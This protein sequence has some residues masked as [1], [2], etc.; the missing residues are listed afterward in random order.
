VSSI[1]VN[2]PRHGLPTASRADLAHIPGNDGWP[3]VGDTFKFLADPLGSVQEMAR[4]YGPVHR[5]RV[6]GIRTVG[7]QGPD[8]IGLVLFDQAK[9]FSSAE[10]WEP[11]LGLLFPRG[12]ML[13]DFDEHRLHR[14]ALSV[15]F[16][17]GPLKAYLAALN[18]GIAER[19]A[20]WRQGP[21]DFLFYPAI[22][23]LTLDLA[24][25]S[26]L[27]EAIG[28]DV[29]AIKRAFIDTVAAATGVIRRP[30]PGTAMRRGVNGRAVIV[31]YFS[32]QAPLRR[33]RG[34][35]DIFSQ[36]CRA[37]HEDGSLMTVQDIA[38]HMNFLMMAAHDTLTSSLSAF[39]YF[40]AGHP[41]WQ[42]K[43]RAEILGLGLAAGE[44][45]PFERLDELRLTEMAFKEAMR[46]IP[47]VIS[48]PR[49]A[50]RDFEFQG[51]RMP[52]GTRVN[53]SI[54][55]THHMPELWP[56]PERFDPQRFSEENSRGRH[57][58]AFAPFGGGAH[59]CLGLHFA[60]MQA[61]CFAYHLLSATKVSTRPGYRPKWQM[62]PIP[63]PRD[64][65]QMT[66]TRLP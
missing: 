64:G 26:F 23:Q 43:L 20:L 42:E 51:Y 58:F 1:A 31:D 12:L 46:L 10:G 59:M 38:D 35:E 40:L 66:F 5:S 50:L 54:I 24:A 9:L 44:P 28:R 8:G 11:F 57:R 25:T 19:L 34:G 60:Y 48:L 65:L 41:D 18:A 17:A 56:E 37:T 3:I 47:P 30:L 53:T 7:L 22:K 61:K 55:F 32:R 6:F 13:L 36:L 52:A 4:R 2:E 27:G 39:V 49:R 33:E 16:K 62:T 63:K 15:A 21:A 45:L 29:E 14:R